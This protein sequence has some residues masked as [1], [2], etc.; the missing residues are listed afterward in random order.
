MAGAVAHDAS[1]A[2]IAYKEELARAITEAL[3]REMP[4]L[5]ERHGER[6]R[7]KCLQDM[8][9]NIEHLTP[10]VAL[11][12]DTLFVQYATWLRDMLASRGV[13]LDEVRRSMELTIDVARAQLQPAHADAVAA[14]V[15]AALAALGSAA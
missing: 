12:D 9:Y 10:A 11:S 13:G 7:T 8:R 15:R 14:P 3:Y 2:L 6:G 5:L 1:E 4:V